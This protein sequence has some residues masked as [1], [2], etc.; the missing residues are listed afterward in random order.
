MRL[1]TRGRYAVTAMLHMALNNRNSNNTPYSLAD[2][3]A[4]LNISLSYLEQIFNRLRRANLVQSFRGASGGYLLSKGHTD[5]TIA[6][7]I[8]AVDES[9]DATH[10]GGKGDCNHGEMCLTH[11]LWEDLTDRIRQFL[12]NI[13]LTQLIETRNIPAAALADIEQMLEFKN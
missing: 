4:S 11:H 6:Q 13:T 8:D 12:E 3:S 7:I 9:I 10:C 5:I 1:T 2:I